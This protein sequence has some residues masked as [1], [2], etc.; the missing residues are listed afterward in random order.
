MRLRLPPAL[1]QVICDILECRIEFRICC[2]SHPTSQPTKKATKGMVSMSVMA[3]VWQGNE[4]VDSS[5]S[6]RQC[7]MQEFHRIDNLG[8]RPCIAV[9]TA[10]RLLVRP[11]IL[12][13]CKQSSLRIKTFMQII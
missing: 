1:D 7:S 11:G 4:K 13:I 9:H 12:D 8:R 10:A 5:P 2:C 6:V 3:Q